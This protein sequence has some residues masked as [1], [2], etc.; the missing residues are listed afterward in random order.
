MTKI[1]D[2]QTV[3]EGAVVARY[4]VRAY[5]VDGEIKY[6]WVADNWDSDELFDSIEE[7]QD[8]ARSR[9]GG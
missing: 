7:A 5:N 6:D 4:I 2:G 3:A 1:T 9:L 8:D